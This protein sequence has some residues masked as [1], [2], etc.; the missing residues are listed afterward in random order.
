MLYDVCDIYDAQIHK[1]NFFPKFDTLQKINSL[2]ENT[3][4]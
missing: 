3:D 1:T 4:I 2:P